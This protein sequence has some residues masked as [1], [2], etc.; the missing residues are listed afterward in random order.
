MENGDRQTTWHSFKDNQPI[1]GKY[2]IA[3]N[4]KNMRRFRIMFTTKNKD[5]SHDF[6]IGENDHDNSYS[7]LI[8]RGISTFDELKGYFWIY[9]EDLVKAFGN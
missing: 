1:Q 2:L 6:M 9:E 5:G 3:W 7:D 8:W 4:G